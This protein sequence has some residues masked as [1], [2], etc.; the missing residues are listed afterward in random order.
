MDAVDTSPRSD[1]ADADT[2]GDDED[3][4]DADD[5]CC[6]WFCGK[7]TPIDDAT[8]DICEDTA[9]FTGLDWSICEYFPRDEELMP[10][11]PR[12]DWPPL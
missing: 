7:P 8:V 4:T 10:L 9:K 3:I 11:H 2:D 6:L 12:I 5:D 1:D